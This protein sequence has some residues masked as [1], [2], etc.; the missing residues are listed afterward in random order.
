MVGFGLGFVMR[1]NG[2][3]KVL[4]MEKENREFFFFKSTA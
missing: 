4:K 3:F 2:A 1:K